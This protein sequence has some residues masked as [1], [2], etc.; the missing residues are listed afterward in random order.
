MYE[1]PALWEQSSITFNPCLAAISIMP[2]IR[3]GVPH[4]CT[5]RMAFV[6]GEI[7]A[8]ISS[9]S[10]VIELSTSEKIG[11]APSRMT[12]PGVATNVTGGILT[13]SPG[14]TPAATRAT[15]I[16]AVPEVTAS[17]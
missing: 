7:L 2:S 16:A 4:R 5:G 11:T 13:S 14:P 1:A 9:G 8:S 17:A 12:A 6:R 15:L 3:Q 10:S